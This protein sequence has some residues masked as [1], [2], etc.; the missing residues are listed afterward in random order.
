M[1]LRGALLE[2]H[3]RKQA[4]KIASWIGND[5][6][7]FSR[8]I[9]LFLHDDYRVV[10]RSAWVLSYVA[11]KH[12]RLIEENIH[13]LVNRLYDKDIH[14][15]VKRNVI[16][17]LQ[18]IPVPLDLQA[19]VMNLCIEFTSNPIETVAVRCFSMTVLCNLAKQY[20]DIKHEVEMIVSSNLKESTAGFKARAKKVLNQLGKIN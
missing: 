5:K 20:P 6:K 12:P 1:D 19:K 8:L 17:V 13:S 7:K 18:F 11:E 3:S 15:A 9:D 14:I 2:E 4:I 10:Q 16:R